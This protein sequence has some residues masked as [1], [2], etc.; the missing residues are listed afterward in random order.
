MT[1]K[2]KTGTNPR[3]VIWGSGGISKEV[4]WII[5]DINRITVSQKY[6]ILGFI[7]KDNKRKGQLLSG[8]QILGDYR[9]LNDLEC[10]SY[11]VPI[12]NPSIKRRII[13]EEIAKI[14]KTINAVNIIHPS[15]MMRDVSVCLGKGNIICAGSILTTDIIIGNHN[16]INL[17]CTI[18]H[19]V[20]LGDYN[21]INPISAI[22][23]GVKIGDSNLIGT[24]TK[25]L[26]N[27]NIK[28]DI[29]IGA[30]AIVTK[31]LD[32]PGIYIGMPAKRIR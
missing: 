15:V 18:G 2:M 12:G 22:S 14:N 11:I 29:T 3:L 1:V 19:D 17:N 5:E 31:D 16:L 28:N 10:D 25:I 21:V 24:G 7:E 4:A 32:E 26:Q 27:I 8:Y 20:T 23:G 30:G 9:V 13:E 6:I